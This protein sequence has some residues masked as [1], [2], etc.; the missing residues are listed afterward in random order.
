M[1]TAIQKWK[2]LCISDTLG[3]LKLKHW[4]KL[5][6]TIIPNNQVFFPD[7][8]IPK[9]SSATERMS[10]EKG[11]GELRVES[12]TGWLLPAVPKSM[13]TLYSELN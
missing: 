5:Y 12:Q 8:H 10:H 4:G 1:E 2:E 3:F 9:H 6:Y 7:I 13:P 11:P